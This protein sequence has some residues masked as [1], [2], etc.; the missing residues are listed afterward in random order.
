MFY[1]PFQNSLS[2]QIIDKTKNVSMKFKIRKML[3]IIVFRRITLNKLYFN[4][5]G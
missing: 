3:R 1:V 4:T 2:K 5:A